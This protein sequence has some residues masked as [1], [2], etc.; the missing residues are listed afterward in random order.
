MNRL[1]KK[2]FVA[3]T[4]CHLLLTVI[5]FVGPAFMSSNP[6]PEDF[7]VLEIVP[8]ITTDAKVSGGGNPNATPP[9][10]APR[11]PTPQ[12]QVTPPAPQ[13]ARVEPVEPP[14]PRES[15]QK[16]ERDAIEPKADD[17]PRKP[18]ISMKVV[19][20]KTN[21]TKSAAKNASSAEAAAQARADAKRSEAFNTAVR[22]LRENLTSGTT[23]EM[24]GPGG[25]GPTYANYK[26]V[27][28]SVYFQ[29]WLVPDDVN[30]DAATAVATVTIAREGNVISARLIRS[31][32]NAVVD[33]SVQ[34][35]LDRVKFIAP[36]PE[37]AKEPQR[38]FT[39]NFNLKA[40]QLL[41]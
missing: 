7:Q 20:R 33:R 6:K 35:T 39:I 34:A 11:P 38:T 29:A 28:G 1:Q 40:K 12:P 37:G 8:D 21:S 4:G 31:S 2:C 15:Q 24:P 32:G 13:P 16:I 3:A 9:P 30:T 41:G 36:F 17:K 14:K 23:V 19:S 10:P 25:G 5:L 27:V 26:Q 18:K 22:S